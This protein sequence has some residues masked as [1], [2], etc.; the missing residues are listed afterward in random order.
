MKT[1]ISHTKIIASGFLMIITVGTLLLMLPFA[2]RSGQSSSFLTA[3]FTATSATCVTGL[4]VVDTYQNWTVF[5]QLVI[6]AMIQIGGL[7]FMTIGIFFSIY[8]RRNISLRERGLMEE[9]V[10][11]L[12]IGGVVKLAKKIMKG[13]VFFEGIG[14]ILL[15]TRFIPRFGLARGIYAGIFHSISAFCNAGF[16]ILGSKEAY[17]SL[18]TYYDDV[19]VNITIMLLII[20]GGIGFIVWDDISKNKLHF[21]KYKLHTKIVLTMTFILVFGGAFLFYLFERNNL[22]LGMNGIEQAMACFFSAVTARTAGFNTIDTAAL[23]SA[24]K[25]FTIVLMF[26]GG[27]PGSTAGGIKTTTIVVLVLAMWSNL[28]KTHGCNVYGR[29]L[30]DSAIAKASTVF[31]INLGLVLIATISI[32]AIQ[33]MPITD[34]MFE[35]TS[36]M[37]TVGMS[38]GI[39]REL[40]SVS[41]VILV[42]LMYTGRIGSMS[43]ALTFAERKHVA[44]VELPVEKITIG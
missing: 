3:L 15:A 35:V 2:S 19:V 29:R 31:L 43:F 44:A 37:G 22:L 10:N 13:T 12:Q 16:D 36:A 30:E 8:L 5:G 4:V 17:T 7:G 34:V 21:H 26:I 18:T 23:T 25:M 33:A 32:C 20:I 42:L 6:L 1:R 40:T 24:S 41:R 39:T 11:T 38:T 14:A 27:S 9:S 28:R